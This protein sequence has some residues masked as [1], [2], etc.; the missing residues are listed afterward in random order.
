MTISHDN[1]NHK[2]KSAAT[3]GPHIKGWCPG[4]VRPMETGDGLLVRIR[5]PAGRFMPELAGQL[6]DAADE[7]G[8]GLID[9][10]QRANIQFRGVKPD[11]LPRLQARL[12]RL[13][14][15]DRDAISEAV[16]NV[17]V[18]PF[19]AD[20]TLRLARLFERILKDSSLLHGLPG[21]FGFVFDDE[22]GS[23]GAGRGDI[24]LM[25]NGAEAIFI[26]DG[27]AGHGVR[28]SRDAAISAVVSAAEAFLEAHQKDASIRRMR[29][30]AA[31][32]GLQ[33]FSQLGHEV[34]AIDL[35]S[36]RRRPPVG[37]LENGVGIGAPF[38]R[39]T[40]AQLRL[41]GQSGAEELR[42]TPWRVLLVI[43]GDGLAI[44]QS[45]EQAGLA[46]SPDDKRLLIDVCPGA[47]ACLS[48]YQDTRRM[49]ERLALYLAGLPADFGS[50]HISGCTKGCA[51]RAEADLVLV[52]T[53]TG[54]DWIEHATATSGIVT[55][56]LDPA[57]VP[58]AVLAHFTGAGKPGLPA[59]EEI[60]H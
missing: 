7:A 4:A 57:T 18:S 17:L 54:Y 42:L 25:E 1:E 36:Q 29:D 24:S 37:M 32:E 56:R 5:I 39:F 9:L 20:G 38:G 8:N 28:L 53:E 21:K 12:K 19:A 51:R 30:L 31:R 2:A 59:G 41:L 52:A 43:G 60:W 33:L 48:A 6:A 26:L 10:S 3:K 47:P 23:L 46:I 15:L 58:G 16:R 49:A 35:P 13:G 22:L 55:G 11:A 34:E 27:M 40:S 50:L 14:L 45:A 44:L